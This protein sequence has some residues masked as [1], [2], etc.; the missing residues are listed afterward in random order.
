MLVVIQTTACMLGLLCTWNTEF[1]NG[2]SDL[3]VCMY[4]YVQYVMCVF[5]ALAIL[6]NAIVYTQI[7]HVHVNT[8]YEMFTF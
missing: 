5:K 4:I 2:Y 1:S 7:A 3:C 8:P 6:D